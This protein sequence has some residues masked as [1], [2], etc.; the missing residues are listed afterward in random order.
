MNGSLSSRPGR[1]SAISFAIPRDFVT[2]FKA[3]LHEPTGSIAR[4]KVLFLS[5]GKKM[6]D[7]ASAGRLAIAEEFSA[8]VRAIMTMRAVI[9]RIDYDLGIALHRARR[10]VP[11]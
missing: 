10:A 5:C 2:R 3:L 11:K 9:D 7:F 4:L 6:Y 8:R 1:S